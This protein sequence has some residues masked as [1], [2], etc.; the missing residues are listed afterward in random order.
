LRSTKVIFSLLEKLWTQKYPSSIFNHL[1]TT[2]TSISPSNNGISKFACTL[3]GV[4][5]P[6]DEDV[7][8]LGSRRR[9]YVNFSIIVFLCRARASLRKSLKGYLAPSYLFS[10]PMSFGSDRCSRFS[11]VST[12]SSLN[13]L[14]PDLVEDIHK[15]K[16]MKRRLL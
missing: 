1:S 10:S 15:E 9:I 6:L 16:K 8:T 2:S 4:V 3:K 5:W 11:K 12:V 14:Y 13:F 7:S